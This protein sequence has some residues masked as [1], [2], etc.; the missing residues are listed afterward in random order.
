MAND[1]VARVWDLM[2]KI[3]FCMLATWNGSELRSRPMDARVRRKENV[4]YFLTDVRHQKDDEVSRFP[5]LNLAFADTD[6]MKYVSLSGEAEMSNDRAKI[7]EL[8]EP[9]AKAWWDSSDNP[10]I[11]LLT[12]TPADAEYWDSP[13]KTISMVKMLVAAATGAKPDVGK[14]D[15][16]AMH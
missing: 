12:V 8:W 15:K 14:N 10:N 16:V 3:S 11:R 6:A 7:K 5:K 1:D 2:E 4:I 13:G 9:T